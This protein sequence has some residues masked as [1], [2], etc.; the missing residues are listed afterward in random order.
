MLPLIGTP[1][2][3]FQA[4]GFLVEGNTFSNYSFGFDIN[5]GGRHTI[6]GN[7]FGP[8]PDTC[9]TVIAQHAVGGK[10]PWTKANKVPCGAISPSVLK[11][12][13]GLGTVPWNSTLWR[14]RYPRFAQMMDKR[15]YCV[16]FN[17]EVL[18]NTYTGVPCDDYP[19]LKGKSGNTAQQL[20]LWN[21][22]AE[23][24]T[25]TIPCTSLGA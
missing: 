17:N 15:T 16:P 4:G 14:T 9:T 20:R 1:W 10:H 21:F 19:V 22:T 25:N 18:N 12:L 11:T 2:C 13:M 23:G 24:N 5:G 6:R 7:R 3:W 8:C